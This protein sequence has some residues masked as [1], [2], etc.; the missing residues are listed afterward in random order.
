MHCKFLNEK[1]KTSA[2]VNG[3]KKILP[4]AFKITADNA[5]V[6]GERVFDCHNIND[7]NRESYESF[8][9]KMVLI[10]SK[11]LAEIKNHVDSS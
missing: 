11:M 6:N 5:N 2:R 3:K 4:P 9:I 8:T 1:E 7:V 10:A